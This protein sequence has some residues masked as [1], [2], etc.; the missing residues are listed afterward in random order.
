MSSGGILLVVSSSFVAGLL[1]ALVL[2]D[3][4]FIC[5]DGVGRLR[6]EPDP[7]LLQ[8]LG[9]LEQDKLVSPSESRRTTTLRMRRLKQT[10]LTDNPGSLSHSAAVSPDLIGRGG[11]IGLKESRPTFCKLQSPLGDDTY[12]P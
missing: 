4:P 6:V 11:F 2:L 10:E 9:V 3:R 1:T 7:E 12:C 5:S 8:V